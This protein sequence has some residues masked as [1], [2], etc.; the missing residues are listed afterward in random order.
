MRELSVSAAAEEHPDRACLIAEGRL[1][2]FAEVATR[3]RSAVTALRDRGIERG[4]RVA[5]VPRADV[6]SV[7]WLYALF[8]LGAP[9][10][11][12][13]PRL[14][15]RER[16]AL[17]RAAAPRYAIE[18]PAPGGDPSQ[19]LPAPSEPPPSETLAVVFTSGSS[20]ASRGSRLS[21]AAFVAAEVAHAKRLGWEE[22]DRWALF[23]P[24]A[25]VGGLSILTRSLIARRCV[26]LGPPGFDA[27][28]VTEV[29][30]RDRVTLCSLVPTML[31]RLL[32]LEPAWS[33]APFLRAV[34][35]GG[36]HYPAALR[37]RA[38]RRA[39]PA[40]ATYGCT[41]ACSQVATQSPSQRGTPGSG[42]PLPG[43]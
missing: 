27:R 42:T 11:L 22:D 28:T 24:P 16:Q 20:G 35:V 7:V 17:M 15:E 3:V 43:E 25:H 31:Q 34:L 30:E 6:D 32:D 8:E 23:M 18:E 10:V 36:A 37:E 13:H 41:E 26:V 21:R 19:S 4:D 1:F 12:L 29:L 33:P 14:T 9:A 39:V 38:E 5:L 2:P 40:L